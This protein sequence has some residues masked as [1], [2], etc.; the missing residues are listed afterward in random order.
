MKQVFSVCR[1]AIINEWRIE[2]MQNKRLKKIICRTRIFLG[3]AGVCSAS[4]CLF[5][6][7]FSWAEEVKME[8]QA[9]EGVEKVLET[10]YRYSAEDPWRQMKLIYQW[11]Q[12]QSAKD[13]EYRRKQKPYRDLFL[14]GRTYKVADDMAEFCLGYNGNEFDTIELGTDVYGR[15]NRPGLPYPWELT[16][17]E[18]E[19]LEPIDIVHRSYDLSVKAIYALSWEPCFGAIIVDRKG[20]VKI[21]AGK[22]YQKLQ[23]YYAMLGHPEIKYKSVFLLDQPSDVRGLGNLQIA[24]ADE[25]KSDDFFMYLPSLRKVRRMSE[26]SKQDSMFGTTLIL[27]DFYPKAPLHTYKILKTEVFKSPGKQV[28]GFNWEFLKTCVNGIGRECWVVE[29]TPKQNWVYAKK[30]MWID[31]ENFLLY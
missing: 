24:Y 28:F 4:I 27:E 7:I 30:I 18:R 20:Q 12:W 8:W 3:V 17:Q 6:P 19:Q 22:Q 10:R 9:G 23:K 2:K 31:K 1:E 15:W 25:S 11:P 14:G 29:V 21:K 16:K 5:L 26:S 13:D